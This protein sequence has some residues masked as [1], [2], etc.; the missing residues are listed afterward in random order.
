M[1]RLS[2]QFGSDVSQAESV[3]ECL[4]L[5]DSR[6]PVVLP[7]PFKTVRY[8]DPFV[9]PGAILDPAATSVFSELRH[10]MATERGNT[11]G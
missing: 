4:Y 2:E 6:R 9:P 8:H 10:K 11:P 7:L 5:L 3:G 1:F